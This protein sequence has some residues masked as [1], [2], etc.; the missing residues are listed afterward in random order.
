MVAHNVLKRRHSS[1]VSIG[2]CQRDVS[3]ERHAETIGIIK[4]VAFAHPSDI[5][6]CR[7][8]LSGTARTKLWQTNC[9]ERLVT[10]KLAAMAA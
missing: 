10:E 8:K 5:A 1:V 7:I 4:S 2:A 9:V 3:E 6:H